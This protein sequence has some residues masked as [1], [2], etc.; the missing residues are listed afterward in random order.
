MT[1]LKCMSFFG[2]NCSEILVA[3]CQSVMYKI[4]VEKGVIVQEVRSPLC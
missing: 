4:D 3:G 1:D 2:K